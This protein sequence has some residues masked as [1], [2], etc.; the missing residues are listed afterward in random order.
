MMSSDALENDEKRFR[1]Y[2]LLSPWQF[3]EFTIFGEPFVDAGG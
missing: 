3:E 2:T 1:R